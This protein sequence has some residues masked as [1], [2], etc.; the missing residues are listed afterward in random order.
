MK[1]WIHASYEVDESWDEWDPFRGKTYYIGGGD[2]SRQESSPV[3]A[4]TQWY[5]FNKKYPMDCYIS[6]KKRDDAIALVKAATPGLLTELTEKYGSPYK[7]E[8]M[9][10][11][12][13]KKVADGCKWFHES[14]KIG[15]VVHPFAVG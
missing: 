14:I 4:I 8:Y 13:A 12:A 1:R 7:L 15:D 5:K 10:D 3:A 6:C 9:I 11:E 2:E